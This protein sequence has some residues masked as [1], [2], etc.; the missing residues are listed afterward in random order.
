MASVKVSQPGAQS[1]THFIYSFLCL[2]VCFVFIRVNWR[3][4]W[5]FSQKKMRSSLNLV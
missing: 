3:C 5:T 4:G 2:C 1:K